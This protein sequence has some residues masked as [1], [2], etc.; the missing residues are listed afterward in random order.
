MKFGSVLRNSQLSSQGA[1]A[2]ACPVQRPCRTFFYCNQTDSLVKRQRKYARRVRSPQPN[3]RKRRQSTH[4]SGLEEIFEAKTVRRSSTTQ[5]ANDAEG[6]ASA[7]PGHEEAC[8]SAEIAQHEA[9][10]AALGV[11]IQL[12][13]MQHKNVDFVPLRNVN[14]GPARASGPQ[15]MRGRRAQCE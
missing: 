2:P 3:R 5:G 12:L 7:R 10:A 6:R 14:C 11:N 4:G 9:R 1:H 15:P 8:L 13:H